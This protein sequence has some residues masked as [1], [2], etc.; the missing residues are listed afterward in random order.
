MFF[1][2]GT[3]SSVIHA[4]GAPGGGTSASPNRLVVLVK[5]KERII[6]HFVEFLRSGIKII[7]MIPRDAFGISAYKNFKGIYYNEDPNRKYQ[8]PETGCHFEYY[9]LCKRLAYLKEKRKVLDVE[10]GLEPIDSPPT[11]KPHMEKHKGSQKG[12]HTLSSNPKRA[13]QANQ[14]IQKKPSIGGAQQIQ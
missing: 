6:H 1:G 5:T 7:T 2:R 13:Q 8:D 11:E 3:T 14:E 12:D 4:A 10:L 9:D